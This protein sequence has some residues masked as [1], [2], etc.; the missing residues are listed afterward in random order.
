MEEAI[1]EAT[2]LSHDSVR[3]L[4][5]RKGSIIADF[6]VRGTMDLV[7]KSMWKIRSQIG[8]A[9]ESGLQRALCRAVMSDSTAE[10][11]VKVMQEY[12]FPAPRGYEDYATA[13]DVSTRPQQEQVQAASTPAGLHMGWILAIVLSSLVVVL[14]FA[15]C[16]IRYLRRVSTSTRQDP[17]VPIVD[18]GPCD[19]TQAD[20]ADKPKP[21]LLACID[22]EKGKP[23]SDEISLAGSTITPT[24]LRDDIEIQSVASGMQ[25]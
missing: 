17:V 25:P 8:K 20:V 22:E 9:S 19:P 16:A 3:L 11:K 6:E 1:I 7:R 13:E 5:I 23:D 4:S 14:A 10:C 2:Q 18:D 21:M 15:L 24:S 12:S